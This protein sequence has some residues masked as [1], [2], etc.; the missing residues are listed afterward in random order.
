MV[1]VLQVEPDMESERSG[2][3]SDQQA[4]PGGVKRLAVKA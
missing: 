4:A 1:T 3:P 2:L